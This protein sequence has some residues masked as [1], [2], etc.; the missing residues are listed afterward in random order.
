[1]YILKHDNV[2]GY[3]STWG[4]F[5]S[6]PTKEEIRDVLE[7]YVIYDDAMMML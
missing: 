3:N 6:Y 2:D 5:D 4:K 7:A 1:M